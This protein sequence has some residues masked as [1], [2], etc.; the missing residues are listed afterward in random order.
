MSDVCSLFQTLQKQLQKVSII[1]PDIIK[2]RY[3]AIDKLNAMKNAPYFGGAEE[4]WV[5]ENGPLTVDG[6]QNSS[7]GTR[8]AKKMHSLVDGLH[9]KRPY[10][11]IRTEVI[12]SATNFLEQTLDSEQEGIMKNVTDICGA[13]SPTNLITSSMPL[14]ECAGISGDQVKEFTD[15]GFEKFH[16][17]KPS[18]GIFEKDY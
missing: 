5:K 9:R 13:K 3:I 11:T 1:I 7:D 8:H 4:K 10:C 2:Y 16:D 18:S 14:L 12:V 17:F 6:T 15:T